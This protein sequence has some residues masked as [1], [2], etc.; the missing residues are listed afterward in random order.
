MS[1]TAVKVDTENTSKSFR[2]GDYVMKL[3]PIKIILFVIS[4]FFVI[5]CGKSNEP[6][7][8]F[9][10]VQKAGKTSY[11]LGT[12]HI[13]NTLE[14]LQCSDKIRN[15]LESSDLLFTEVDIHSEEQ[16]EFNKEIEEKNKK[17]IQSEDGREF[18]SLNKDSQIFFRSRAVPENL[19]Y[20]GYA[21][22][23]SA[24]CQNQAKVKS[25]AGAVSLDAQFSAISQA[26]N[27]PVKYLDEGMDVKAVA[28][29]LSISTSDDLSG[30]NA[31]FVD[32]TVAGF[33]S[34]IAQYEKMIISYRGGALNVNLL[35]AGF[36]SEQKK[37]LLK[38]RNE[39]WVAKFKK[40]HRDSDYDQI[41]LAGGTAHFIADFNVIDMLK[42]DGFSISRMNAD[43]DY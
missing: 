30:V 38:D 41:F 27:I 10:R 9:W 19:T 2:K 35:N 24:L 5:S 21:G 36:D 32:T 22:I 16:K 43:C 14:H 33:E 20:I 39:E 23:V 40:A 28:E 7:P 18:K 17:L 37:V 34:C 11:F 15:H 31:A 42:K 25:G 12:F 13:A 26:N 8:Y 4:F 3:Q 1:K 29:S 6:G